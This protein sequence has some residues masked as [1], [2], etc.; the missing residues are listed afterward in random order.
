MPR[1]IY[2]C[3]Y[4]KDAPQAHLSNFVEY[5]ATRDGVDKITNPDLL[6]PATKKQQ[7]LIAQILRELPDTA[8]M[9][10]HEDY[11]KNPTRENASEFITRAL[12]NNLDLIGKRKNFV[13]YVANRPRVERIGTHGL[14]TD[15]GQPVV[16][17]QVQDEVSSHTG[18]VWTNVVSLR[19]EDA[20]RLGYD[21]AASWQALMRSQRNILAESMKI[22]PENL[23]WYAAYHDEGH[24][25]HIH[26]IAYS[27]DPS[28]AYVTKQGIEK[29]RSSLAR[30]IFKQDLVQIYQ[31]QTDSRKELNLQSKNVMR[32]LIAELRSG[33]CANKTIEDDIQL[34]SDRLQKTGGK[35]VYGYLKADV[36]AIVNR[37]VDELAK[38]ERVSKCYAEWCALRG[39]VLQTYTGKPP[40]PVP[41][42]QQKEFKSIKNMVIAEAMNIGDH[43]FIFEPDE[44]HDEAAVLDD[45]ANPETDAPM[46]MPE[47]A[48]EPDDGQPEEEAPDRH[49]G[50]NAEWSDRYKEARSFLF[51]SK[52]VEQDFAEAHRLFMEEAENGNALAMHDLGRMHMDG[53]GMEIS[54]EAAQEWYQKSLIA[55]MAVESE[56]PRPYI[57]YRIGKLHNAGLGTP[58]DYSQAAR[59][60]E[61]AAEENHKYA[62][63]SLAGLYY[64]GQGVSQDFA[65]AFE[66]YQKSAAQGNAY[67][68]Y[69]LAKMFRDGIGTGKNMS[70]ADRHFKTAFDGFLLL[71]AR[72]RDDKLQYR[73]GQMLQTGTGTEQNTAAAIQYF[74][75]AAK[76]GNVNA[77]Y[78]LAKIYL[79]IGGEHENVAKALEWM[80]KATDSGNPLAQYAMAKLYLAGDHV[81]KDAAKAVE[82]FTK[83]AEQN[84]Q[85][86][87]YALGKL[88]LT[89]EDAPKDVEAAIRWLT[90]AAE[91]SNQF[92][93]YALGKLY[94]SG[95]DVSKDMEA[96]IRWLTAAAEQN[97]QYAQYTL[98][99]L[100]LSGED[101]S[102]DVEAAL[103]W[104]TAAAE[105]SNQYA[106]YSLGKLYLSGEDAPKDVE[107]AIRWL[108][109][110]AEQNN[111][112]AQ[113]ALGK[114]YLMG[115]DVPRDREQAERW[116]TLS[117]AQ[118]NVYAQFLLER[119]DSFRDPSILLAATRL[120][121]HL[122]NIFDDKQRPMGSGDRQ[123]DRKLRRKLTE[124]KS[125]QGHA[126]DDHAPQLTY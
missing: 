2:K 40:D 5:V 9:F 104:L 1:I 18:N 12:E 67:A 66:L 94:L 4:L 30:E 57:Q 121:R 120:L 29:M 106:Q 19:R 88:Y 87:Q 108:T 96:A 61:M 115:R 21:N 62:Q 91:Q 27:T 93:Q 38:D 58:Q 39:E 119:I 72:S 16:L 43:R 76:L 63:Y 45:S 20:T 64:R 37:I 107:A 14:F 89:G 22:V 109:A 53:L 78:A 23:R 74:E 100:Y 60:F 79:D 103:R 73:L 125:A 54:T 51:G 48:L 55:F 47:D 99:K 113:Y 41:L 118:G 10:E 90:A 98:G 69:E 92:A 122:G 8:D 97:N 28:E 86:A 17:S 68:S 36:K 31:R 77:Q 11:I 85:F 111:Q 116:L 112:Y 15:A 114:L 101:V 95:E 124:K 46:E 49:R 33:V 32:R 35:K 102:K 126:H 82:L 24:H 13:D 110:A 6:L 75:Q 59:W 25:P 52:T 44:D 105:Q 117:A 81:E 50:Y 3:R 70:E 80:G 84:N 123:I 56:K 65:R 26:L 42:S 7:A 83:S 71:E 34:L